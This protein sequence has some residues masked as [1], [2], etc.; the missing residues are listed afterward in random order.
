MYYVAKLMD[1]NG[2]V[3]V[4]KMENEDIARE[5]YEQYQRDGMIAQTD[6]GNMGICGDCMREGKTVAEARATDEV[7][8]L[9][10]CK[11]HLKASGRNLLQARNV[12]YF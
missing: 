11:R 10:Y 12:R 6:A 3:G 4:L 2:N 7:Q 5:T 1:L 8:Y 9:Q